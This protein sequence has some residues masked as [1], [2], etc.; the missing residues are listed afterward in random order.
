MSRLIKCGRFKELKKLADLF[1]LILIQVKAVS[2]FRRIKSRH[3]W[4]FGG[5]YERKTEFEMSH[6]ILKYNLLKCSTCHHWLA[7]NWEALS[8]HCTHHESRVTKFKRSSSNNGRTLK[9][10][11]RRGKGE[12]YFQAQRSNK[13]KP[14]DFNSNLEE[15]V[16]FSIKLLPSSLHNFNFI[17]INRRSRSPYR[18]LELS[19]WPYISGNPLLQSKLV[20]RHPGRTTRS[21]SYYWMLVWRGRHLPLS[22]AFLK[23]WRLPCLRTH[24]ALRLSLLLCE[25]I[26]Y[27]L[28]FRTLQIKLPFHKH[29]VSS[30]I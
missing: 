15:L 16:K 30:Q 6:G 5:Q 14:F 24:S 12:K 26:S 27:W 25:A 3:L 1:R 11:R 22:R 13:W 28:R 18:G 20:L 8:R 23:S 10:R 4:L 29:R 21:S 7:D 19:G 9:K 2:Y 17:R